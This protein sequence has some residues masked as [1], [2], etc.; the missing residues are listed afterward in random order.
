MIDCVNYVN[1]LINNTVFIQYNLRQKQINDW[2]C[3][4]C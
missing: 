3:K 4:L 1:K 2:S